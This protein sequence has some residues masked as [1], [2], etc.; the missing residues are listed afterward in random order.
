ML[1]REHAAQG[2]GEQNGERGETHFGGSNGEDR[3]SEYRGTDRQVY[4]RK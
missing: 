3:G 4:I 2:D 1:L